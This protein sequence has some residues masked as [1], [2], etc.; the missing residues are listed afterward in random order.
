MLVG[1]STPRLYFRDNVVA[2]F[3]DVVPSTDEY[4]G[5]I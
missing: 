4:S 2:L 1:F 5:I 3:G